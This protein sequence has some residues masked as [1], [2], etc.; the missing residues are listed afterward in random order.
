MGGEE[1]GEAG[2]EG[3][4][5]EGVEDKGLAVGGRAEGFNKLFRSGSRGFDAMRQLDRHPSL[6]QKLQRFLKRTSALPMET[7][8]AG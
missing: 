4:E 5:R 1:E 7:A 8:H 2:K 6:P 3:A